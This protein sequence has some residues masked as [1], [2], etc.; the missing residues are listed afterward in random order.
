VRKIANFPI[1]TFSHTFS[2]NI[3]KQFFNILGIKNKNKILNRPFL[4]KDMIFLVFPPWPFQAKM[5]A[6]GNLYNFFVFACTGT[7]KPSHYIPGTAKF[8]CQNKKK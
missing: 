7:V 4:T 1:A 2:Y 8:V 3:F 6:E 5:P